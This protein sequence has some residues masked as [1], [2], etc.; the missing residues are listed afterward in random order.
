MCSCN[1]IVRVLRTV[2][3]K[4]FKNVERGWY[5]NVLCNLY[6]QL[7]TD[8]FVFLLLWVCWNKYC[9]HVSLFA[10]NLEA[11]FFMY[12]PE[13]GVD[14]WII[15]GWISRGWDVGMWTGLG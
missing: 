15:L 14:G 5:R 9:E 13:D 12:Q 10:Y 2:Y 3:C 6:I 11:K 8:I 7:H 1:A 4:V